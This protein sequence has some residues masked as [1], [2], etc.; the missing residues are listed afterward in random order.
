MS[1]YDASIRVGTKVNTKSAEV[2]LERL[3]NRIVKTSDKIA[4]LRSKMDALKD[5]KIP[6]QEYIAA[7]KEVDKYSNALQKAKE[8]IDKLLELGVDKKSSRFTS[9]QYEVAQ[10]ENKLLD[11]EDVVKRLERE[12]KAFTL[13]SDTEEYKKL[14]QQLQYAEKDLSVLEKSY[15]VLGAKNSETQASYV[16]L[17]DVVKQTFKTMA[18]GFIDIPIAATKAGINGLASAFRKLGNIAKDTAVRSFKMLGSSIKGA[19][20]KAGSLI[21]SMVSKL[22]S[23]GSAAKKSFSDMNRSAQKSSGLFNTF[24]SRLKGITLSLLVF[25]W[26]TKAFNGAVTA[27]KRGFE[28]LYKDNE[29]FKDSVDEL[30][31]S[32]LTLKNAFAA[33]FRPL[34][35]VAIPYIRM[36][37]DYLTGFLNKVG[38]FMAAI[39]GQKTYTRAIRQ[40]VD[41]FKDAKKAAE[42]YLSPLD[43]INRYSD[44]KSKDEDGQTGVVFEELPVESKFKDMAEK[45]KNVFKDIFAPIREAWNPEGKFVID[46]WKYGLG[47]IGKLAKDIG[48]DFLKV[49]KQPE[50]VAMLQNILHIFGDIGLIVGN[51]ALKFREAWNENNVGLHILENIRDIFAVIIHNIREATDYTVE[52]TKTLDFVPL[53]QGIERLTASL[54][55]FFDFLSGTLADFY[56]QFLLPLASWTLS[57]E[58]IPRLLNVLADFM[59]SVDWQG[60]REALKN[61][62]AAL[63]PYAEKIGTG[64]IDFIERIKG[65]GV[66]FLNFLPEHIS[67]AADAL[68]NGD[69]P[70]AFEEFGHISGEAVKTAFNF[71]RD[72]IN[73]IPWGDIGVWIGS[74]INGIKWGEVSDSF[75]GMF[76]D[77]W[78]GIINGIYNI[79]ITTKWGDIGKQ[80]GTSF[81]NALMNI[82]WAETGRTL[83]ETF[84]AFFIFVYEAIE[85]VDWY[86]IGQKAKEFIVNIDWN[87]VAD[88]FFRAVGAVFGGFAA[89]LWGIIEEAWDSVVQWWHDTA[90]EDGEFTIQGLLDG[91]VEAVLDIANWVKEHIFQPFI[92]GFKNAFGIHSPSTVMMEM[93][94]Y[95]IQGLLDGINSLVENVTAIWQSMKETVVGIWNTIKTTLQGI[96][97]NIKTTASTVWN[98]IKSTLQGIWNGIKTIVS[99]VFDGIKTKLYGIWNSIKTTVL[100]VWGTISS[101]ITGVIDTISGKIESFI[102]KIRDAINAVKDFLSSGFDK[103]KSGVQSAFGGG[104]ST[105]SYSTL[106]YAMRSMQA[107]YD[108][109]PVIAKLSNIEIPGYAT[110]QVIPTSMKKHLAWLGD[111]PKETEVVSPLST[112][113][114]ANK[115]SLLEVLSELG[116][117][118]GI[119]SN[120]IP[121]IILKLFFDSKVVYEAMIKEGKVRQMASGTND[122]LLGTI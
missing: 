32:A 86:G 110:G 42:G 37:A 12:G 106:P 80:I 78:N 10:L 74:F 71:I 69:L 47:E 79:I 8:K 27:I 2:Q 28:N 11:A 108:Y 82:N 85:A 109:S 45:V 16:H 48:R 44:G 75:F 64:L 112:I 73:S 120:D 76:V 53:L 52:W 103:I 26:I 35:D 13:G 92:D 25:N 91:I 101:K 97:N 40:T 46:S 23:L 88:A 60:L 43:E 38:Q 29:K 115:E 104:E 6:T 65:Y 63:E 1:N 55:P 68:R 95:I 49:W 111:N 113:K 84:K 18:R 31:A 51:L 56:T 114:Q 118:G 105:Q 87:G 77:L 3:E 14:G 98:S 81:S 96:W 50:T 102:G 21:G 99:T 7:Q 122:F 19:L 117:T 89:F 57:E 58:G 22:K 15:D 9:A 90:Y 94:T 33:A 62:Y 54:V 119:R 17:G 67:K 72:T 4:S 39:T 107:A 20:S 61:L 93:G 121:P 116:L 36:A 24:A 83:S 5:V 41:A 100:G 34:V 70:T 30:R 59:E 66:E